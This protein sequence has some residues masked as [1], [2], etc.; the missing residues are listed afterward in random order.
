MKNQEQGITIR[1]R[2][3]G[4]IFI[5]GF[6]LIGWRAFDLQ[7]LQV[8]E[9]EERA[10]RQHQ[11]VVPLTAQRGTIFD[12]HGEELAVSVEVD[13]IYAE[14]NKLEDPKATAKVLAKALDLPTKRNDTQASKNGN[15]NTPKAAP[16]PRE[17]FGSWLQW[18][19]ATTGRQTNSR[20]IEIQCNRN[21]PLLLLRFDATAGGVFD[22]EFG[23]VG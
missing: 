12:S 2:I 15:R 11:K 23:T 22:V 14:P 9:W 8:N 19:S 5:L 16:T 1:I 3:V 7:V 4:V 17:M 6:A 13:S 20:T 18:I 21:L 10:E